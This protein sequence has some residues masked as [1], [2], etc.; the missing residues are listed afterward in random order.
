MKPALS[1]TF[2]IILQCLLKSGPFKRCGLAASGEPVFFNTP[3]PEYIHM[4]SQKRPVHEEFHFGFV[5]A[6]LGIALTS[7]FGFAAIL[8]IQFGFGLSM[9]DGWSA[10]LQAHGHAQLMGWTGLFIMGVSLHFFPRLAGTSLSRPY[11]L[12]WILALLVSGILLR[13]L[14]QPLLD[15]GPSPGLQTVLRI[16]LGMSGIAET[17]GVFGYLFLLVSTASKAGSNRP[18]FQS[19]SV[20]F[21]LAAVGWLTYVPISAVLSFQAATRGSGMVDIA[22][23][24]FGIELFIALVLLP[25]AMAFTVRTFPLYLRLP[26][27]RWPVHKLGCIYLVA[28]TLIHVPVL[29]ELLGV[30]SGHVR[31]TQSFIGIGRILKGGVLLYFIWKIDLLIRRCPPWTVN[32]MG[33]PGPERRPTRKGLP[34]YGEF[35][36]FEWLLYAA[37]TALALAAC[38]ELL[39]GL[40]AL[41]NWPSP[42]DPDALRHTYLAGFITLLLFGMAPRLIPGFLHKRQVAYPSLVTVTFFLAGTAAL[43]RILPL[44]MSNI[45]DR[46]PYGLPVALTAFGLSGAFGWLAVGVLAVNLYATWC[47]PSK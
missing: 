15:S 32:R 16:A 9:G 11:L 4:P 26:A 6:A 18:A 41:L 22:W 17:I 29:A 23:N 43:F 44:F 19:V 14:S 46:I 47:Q 21:S 42:A 37:Y 5:L 40:S 7:G 2:C 38:L 45:L 34:D 8:S 33:A 35:G 25:V 10:L 20:F 39:E 28:L 13:T 36:R 12:P 31:S 1:G 27:V 30:I 3:A 24:R